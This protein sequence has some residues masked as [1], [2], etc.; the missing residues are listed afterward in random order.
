LN[1]NYYHKCKELFKREKERIFQDFI[2][3]WECLI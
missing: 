1:L 2:G 3:I